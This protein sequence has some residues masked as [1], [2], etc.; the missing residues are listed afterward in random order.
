MERLQAPLDLP[1]VGSPDW[2]ERMR[3]AG[4]RLRAARVDAIYLIHG[5]FVGDDSFGV[6]R[7]LSRFVPSLASGGRLQKRLVDLLLG[8]LGDYPPRYARELARG[9]G[10]AL[11]ADDGVSASSDDSLAPRVRRFVWDG[12]DNH[13]GRACGAVR[14]LVDL[15]RR[16]AEGVGRALL[17]GHS[18]GG[19][20]LALATNLL[21]ADDATRAR[22]FEALEPNERRWTSG[23]ADEESDVRAARRILDD[24]RSP[25]R[26][27][28]LDVVTFGTPVR[29]GWDSLGYARLLHLVHHRP[30][31]VRERRARGLPFR[32]LDAWTAREGDYVQRVGVAGTNFPP[33]RLFR[34]PARRADRGLHGLLQAEVSSGRLFDKLRPALRT[35]DEGPT[36]AIDY[37]PQRGGPLRHLFGHGIYTRRRWM[38]LHV[39]QVVE[40]WYGE[41]A[42]VASG[43]QGVQG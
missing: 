8:D 18:H 39:E 30:G 7:E 1:L 3:R 4:E 6:W 29:Y 12:Q 43:T 25:V 21:A 37:G 31:G 27:L 28:E 22:F 13:L 33:C 17:W 11:A 40:R 36:L 16:A 20:L 9:L 14:L 41:S 26:R 10:G 35:M 34:R 32:L 24:P 5:T 42:S 38:L 2:V 19:N 15:E 23:E